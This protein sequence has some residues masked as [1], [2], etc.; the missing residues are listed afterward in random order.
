MATSDMVPSTP[1]VMCAVSLEANE[2]RD[3]AV[4]PRPR[5]EETTSLMD[6]PSLKAALMTSLLV[7]PAAPATVREEVGVERDVTAAAESLTCAFI[8]DDAV[9][10]VPLTRTTSGD[11]PLTTLLTTVATAVA[12]EVKVVKLVTPYEVVSVSVSVADTVSCW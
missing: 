11:T 12:F 8:A 10:N 7:A 3:E 2:M 6:V 4:K 9:E 5:A 1:T